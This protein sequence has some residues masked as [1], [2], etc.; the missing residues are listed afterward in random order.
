MR[1]RR[2][3]STGAGSN[4]VGLSHSV[5]QLRSLACDE[6]EVEGAGGDSVYPQRPSTE[7]IPSEAEGLGPSG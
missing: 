7:F 3:S 2:K 5:L 1:R 6:A 4:L